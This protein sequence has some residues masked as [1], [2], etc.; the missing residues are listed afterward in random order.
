[1][2]E[3]GL[4]GGHGLTA[5]QRLLNAHD[6]RLTSDGEEWVVGVGLGQKVKE[7]VGGML[8]FALIGVRKRLRRPLTQAAQ[9]MRFV[10]V[11]AVKQVP[12]MRIF[13]LTT[14]RIMRF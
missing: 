13:L 6:N 2:V 7:N 1:M 11:E 8:F 3:N 12:L 10:E 5:C 9:G 4:Q 14:C